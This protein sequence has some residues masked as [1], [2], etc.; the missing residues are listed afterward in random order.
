MNERGLID[1]ILRF[2][3]GDRNAF[4]DLVEQY[5]PRLSVFFYRHFWDRAQ[6]EDLAQEV[7]LKILRAI[8][9][10][11]PQGCP[12]TYVWRVARN[13]LIDHLRSVKARPKVASLESKHADDETTR[14]LAAETPDDQQGP[15][16]TLTR[17][18]SLERLRCALEALSTEQRLVFEMGVLEGL[19]YAD[20]AEVLD[21]PVGTVK[22]RIFN[23]VRVLRKRLP[24]LVR[25]GREGSADSRPP[26]RG[27]GFG[28]TW[29]D[30]FRLGAG[31]EQRAPVVRDEAQLYRLAGGN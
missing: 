5:A 14:D 24:D 29:R 3:E 6:A 12:D 30:F 16:D 23:A 22:S 13:V 20:I 26:F 27:G 19:R 21:I 28:R 31:R 15:L 11:E 1:P 18:E 2:R 7:F 4:N 10:Y 17:L 25:E 8:D 9:R